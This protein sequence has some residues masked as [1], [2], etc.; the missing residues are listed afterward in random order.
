MEE[1][2]VE[3]SNPPAPGVASIHPRSLMIPEPSEQPRSVCRSYLQPPYFII[4]L[5]E[6]E[7]EI[8]PSGL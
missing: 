2:E 7:K 5:D 3:A 6:D 1:R 4:A 8:G